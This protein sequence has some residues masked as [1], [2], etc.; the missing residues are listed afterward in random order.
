[1]RIPDGL[2]EEDEFFEA[3]V[4]V[5]SY[6]KRKECLTFLPMRHQVTGVEEFVVRLEVSGPRGEI[7]LEE[8]TE[9]RVVEQGSEE[10][11]TNH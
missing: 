2:C 10:A 7:T 5:L 4:W 3:L 6:L 1:M 8:S 9:K 11:E